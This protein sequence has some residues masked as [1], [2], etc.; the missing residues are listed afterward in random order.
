MENETELAGSE[1]APEEPGF[2]S[3]GLDPRIVSAIEGMGFESPTP[4]QREAIPKTLTGRDVLGRARTGSGK[5]AAFGLPL[6]ERVKT[7]GRQVRALVLAPT[8]ELALQVTGALQDFAQNLPVRIVTVYG[9]ASYGPQLSALRDGVAVV[10]GTPGRVLDYLERG[11]LDLSQLEMLVLDEADEMLRMGFIDDVERVLEA[12]PDSCQVALFSATMP[13]AIR[14]VANAHLSDPIEVQVESSALSVGHIEQRYVVVPQGHKAEAL[15]RVLAAKTEGTTIVFARTRAGA[16]EAA[17]V[18][19]NRGLPVD[20]LHGDL[21]QGARER[22][23]ARLRSGRLGIVVATDVAARGL[24]IDHVTHVINLDLPP[25]PEEY[26]HRIGRTGRAGREGHAIS[27][28]TPSEESRLRAFQRLLKVTIAPMDVPTDATIARARKARLRAQVLEVA[29]NETAPELSAFVED[30][31]TELEPDAIA[32]T[33]LG[34]LADARG[35]D[36]HEGSDQPPHW[37]RRFAE[38]RA[39]EQEPRGGRRERRDDF[40]APRSRPRGPAVEGDELEIVVGVGRARGVRAQDLVGAIANEAD[41][42]GSAIGKISIVDRASFVKVPRSVAEH[43]LKHHRSLIVRGRPARI[44]LARGVPPARDRRDEKRARDDERGFDEAEGGVDGGGVDGGGLEERDE[45]PRV[46]GGPGRDDRGFG[47][48]DEGGEDR[49][50]RG[51]GGPRRD[52][53]GFG[54]GEGPRRGFGGP[55]RDDRGFGGPRRDDA[56]EE[57]GVEASWGDFEGPSESSGEERPKRAFGK[58]AFGKKP[59]GKKPFG[60]K[61]FGSKKPGGFAPPKRKR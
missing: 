40:D 37:A 51:F 14:R 61:G 54:G 12:A 41:V 59:F 2:A 29:A 36:L 34:L 46:F 35:L 31:K 55:R 11:S 52:D 7:G 21:N 33:L 18:L 42:P 50:R 32:T 15:A 60:K 9:G 25:R 4:I 56:G 19:A 13:D 45:R 20:A 39:R 30:L 47:G 53:R 22:V 23:I 48:R 27:F 6:L 28:V 17:D 49:P 10:V 57:R 58:P 16:A 1:G 24:D 43:L 5:T 3:F 38:R 8:R 44:D 26:V